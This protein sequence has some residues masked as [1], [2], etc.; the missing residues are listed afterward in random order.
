MIVKR[1]V[2]CLLTGAC[3]LSACQPLTVAAPPPTLALP[4]PIT[5]DVSQSVEPVKAAARA[6]LD[7]WQVE[8]FPSMYALL[9]SVSKDAISADDFNTH[10]H[11][12][13]QEAALSEVRYELLG[14]G[15]EPGALWLEQV[16]GKWDRR[17]ASLK[18]HL[19]E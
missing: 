2:R 1:A 10:Y 16:G 11:S 6:Y 15:L 9:T 3:L 8:D 14:D 17:L 13:S 12:I 19:D 18:R 7:A 5:A 4:T